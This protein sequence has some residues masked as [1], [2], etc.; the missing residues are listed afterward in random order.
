M[1]HAADLG[2][3][4]KGAVLSEVHQMMAE[5]RDENLAFQSQMNAKLDQLMAALAPTA[6]GERLRTPASGVRTK[7]SEI[8]PRPSI[9][10]L[11]MDPA[12]LVSRRL[13]LSREPN[14]L[15]ALDGKSVVLRNPPQ[16]VKS[17][18]RIDSPCAYIVWWRQLTNEIIKSGNQLSDISVVPYIADSARKKLE[19]ILTAQIPQSPLS[20]LFG[21]AD[22]NV[23]SLSNDDVLTIL[24]FARAPVTEKEFIDRFTEDFH[25]LLK[26]SRD[27]EADTERMQDM[28]SAMFNFFVANEILYKD[29]CAFGGVDSSPEISF[30]EEKKNGF[31]G[32]GNGML[33][34]LSK[35]L[36]LKMDPESQEYHFI[37]T[38]WKSALK[39]AGEIQIKDLKRNESKPLAYQAF[40]KY[41][42][43]AI[44]DWK[45]QIRQKPL[46]Y[47]R[48]SLSKPSSDKP[49]ANKVH[50]F[51]AS[52]EESVEDENELFV[53][54]GDAKSKPDWKVRRG[55]LQVLSRTA[56]NSIHGG[57]AEAKSKPDAVRDNQGCLTWIMSGECDNKLKNKCKWSHD[58]IDC[59]KTWLVQFDRMCRSKFANPVYTDALKGVLTRID[60]EKL[61]RQS[62]SE[63]MDIYDE[64]QRKQESA[65]T[66]D[67][68][69]VILNEH[70][71]ASHVF[72]LSEKTSAIL[73]SEVSYIETQSLAN[74]REQVPIPSPENAGLFTHDDVFGSHP[75]AARETLLALRRSTLDSREQN[76]DFR[77]V[78]SPT[79]HSL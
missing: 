5:Q 26:I 38:V 57:G 39:D 71:I 67:E 9:F 17:L 60:P 70:N 12:E 48:F 15:A 52:H 8:K 31:A 61:T 63:F 10:P 34:L 14:P 73:E 40:T 6:R 50:A 42:I 76:K 4:I 49:G 1:A 43:T 79:H 78:S 7:E 24:A 3:E 28:L 23:N 13:T 33:T 2:E 21:D 30:S 74:I 18:L 56:P 54:S 37:H 51:A 41:M 47:S 65:E 44:Y 32:T 29:M 35:K 45:N 22:G 59:K 20:E 27:P 16:D 64:L 77:V 55:S 58:P 62:V 36:F 53:M 75:P 25:I 69:A 46:F 68:L 19:F 66:Y 11:R 72:D